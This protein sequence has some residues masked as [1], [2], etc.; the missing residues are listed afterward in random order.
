MRQTLFYNCFWP[1]DMMKLHLYIDRY[2]LE[3]EVTDPTYCR[4][5]AGGYGLFYLTSSR[6]Y[7]PD[8]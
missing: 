1:E 4:S 6:E 8:L 7:P 5:W 2:L 3:L